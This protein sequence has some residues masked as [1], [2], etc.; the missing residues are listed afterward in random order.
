MANLKLK[1]RHRL[2]CGDCTDDQVAARLFDGERAEACITDPPYNVDYGNAKHQKFKVREIENDNMSKDDYQAFGL[3][4]ANQIKANTRGCVYV[5]GAPA[6]D[7]RI[8][9]SVLDQTLHCSTTIIWNKDVFVLGRAK[10]HNKYEP[11]WFG[12]NESGIRFTDNRKLTNVWDYERPKRSQEHPTMKPVGLIQI[13]IEHATREGDIVF[14]LFLGSGTTL[15][16]CEQ[17]NRRCFGTEISP[18]Y[19]DVIVARWEALTGQTAVK[20]SGDE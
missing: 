20:Q 4:I 11:C 17:T 3:L 5:F 6:Q 13:P 14:D 15:I 10:Y 2:L 1:S 19:C 8:L 9:F 16:A 12:W 7:G 18:R